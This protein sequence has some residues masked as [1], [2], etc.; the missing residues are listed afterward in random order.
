MSPRGKLNAQ[1]GIIVKGS[2]IVPRLGLCNKV[3]VEPKTSVVAVD[4]V[5]V[6]G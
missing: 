3:N 5:V 1:L 4:V 6:V 2:E